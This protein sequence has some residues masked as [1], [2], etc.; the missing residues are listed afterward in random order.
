M[1]TSL[2]LT[3]NVYRGFSGKFDMV[4]ENKEFQIREKNGS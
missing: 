3:F 1:N 4:Y 2:A